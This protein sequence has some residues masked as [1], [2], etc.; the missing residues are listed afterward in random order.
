VPDQKPVF[1]DR[2]SRAGR[3]GFGW[4]DSFNPAFILSRAGRSG[5]SMDKGFKEL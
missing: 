1:L 4:Q 5:W 2:I 3:S